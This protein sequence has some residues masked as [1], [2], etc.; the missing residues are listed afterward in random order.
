M[1]VIAKCLFGLL[2]A[3]QLS[4]CQADVDYSKKPAA[5][6]LANELA[7]DG[8]NSEWVLAQLKGAK[9]QDS[10]LDAMSSPAESTLTWGEYRDIFIS[11]KRVRLG[12]EFWQK[13]KKWFAKAKK[14]YGVPSHI[15]LAILGVE[16]YYGRN[17]GGY[18]V[19]DALATLGFD[20]KPRS[21]FF[22][23]QLKAFFVLSQK[24]HISLTET[25]GSYAGAMGYGQ[26]IPTSYLAYAVDFNKD[27]TTDL[28]NSIPDAIGS[29]ANYFAV[30]GWQPGL[31][32]AAKTQLTKDGAKA[33]FEDGSLKPG[34]TLAAAEKA[35]I[36]PQACSKAVQRYCFANLPADTQVA[37]LDFEGDDGMQYWL[38]TDNFYT[39]TRYNHSSLYGMAVYQLASLIKAAQADAGQ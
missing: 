19:L 34:I 32:V 27:G 26:F 2:L 35:G 25:R 10:I 9:R 12:L 21:E 14:E 6:T 36:Q 37:P 31:P 16:T 15:I 20:Y 7:A 39:I 8:F 17:M 1:K 22:L 5:K 11:D 23:K 3:C 24:A 30:H 4:A 29:I 28:M 18:R 13:H 33:L 38:G